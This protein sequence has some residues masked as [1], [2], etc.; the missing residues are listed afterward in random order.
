M[1]NDCGPAISIVIA[2]Y[3]NNRL[4]DICE[5]LKSIN[6]EPED[7]FEVICVIGKSKELHG[8]INDFVKV[9]IAKKV[10]I[11]LN[12]G[13]YRL[14]VQRNLGIEKASSNIVAFVDDD[15]ILMPNWINA[16]V[17]AF[18]SPEVVGV[19]G[20]AV[21]LWESED[22]NWLPRE[23]WWITACTG[24]FDSTRSHEV[25]NAWGMNMAFR[26]SALKSVGGFNTCIGMRGK[27]GLV[28][29]EVDLSLRIRELTEKKILFVPEMAVYHKV[30]AYRTSFSFIRQRSYSV[31]KGRVFIKKSFSGK[32]VGKSILNPE[33]NLLKRIFSRLVPE[34]ILNLFTRPVKGLKQLVCTFTV[35]GFTGAGFAIASLHSSLRP[36]DFLS[37]AGKISNSK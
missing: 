1:A 34:I 25:R 20:P 16:V 33:V 37:S 12:M 24:W 28:V 32:E 6:N 8:K 15:A 13:D 35:L 36:D 14:N 23:F 18:E 30:K 26:T 27:K 31:G 21:P 17:K 9:N 5:L 22:L 29:G 19:T 4:Y 3:D 2:A 11:I 7:N 10:K